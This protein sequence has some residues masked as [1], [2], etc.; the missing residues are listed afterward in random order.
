MLPTGMTP[1]DTARIIDYHRFYKPNIK[2]FKKGFEVSVGSKN[3]T[4]S[5]KEA[6]LELISTDEKIFP[7]N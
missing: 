6:V 1:A 5:I 4:K 7:S 3:L 2:D